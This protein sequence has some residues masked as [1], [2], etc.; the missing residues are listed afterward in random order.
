LRLLLTVGTPG[1]ASSVQPSNIADPQTYRPG[2]EG[3]LEA[4]AAFRGVMGNDLK[5]GGAS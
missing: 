1:P 5:R 2:M 4:Y 3:G